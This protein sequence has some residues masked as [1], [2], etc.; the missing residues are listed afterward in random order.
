MPTTD[1]KYVWP[2]SA[3]TASDMALLHAVR[4]SSGVRSTI[5]GLVA[6]AVRAAYGTTAACAAPGLQTPPAP[7]GASTKGNT[8]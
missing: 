4:E 8:Q 7:Y 1:K 2:A 5:S 3:L 6:V